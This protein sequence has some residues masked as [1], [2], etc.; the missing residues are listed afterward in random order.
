MG[1]EFYSIKAVNNDTKDMLTFT[2]VYRLQPATLIKILHKSFS[3][4]TFLDTI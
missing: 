2:D 1:S 3:N 4:A